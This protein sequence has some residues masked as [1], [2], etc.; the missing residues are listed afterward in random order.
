MQPTLF[1]CQL[2]S[3]FC[4]YDAV[5]RIIPVDAIGE[6]YAGFFFGFLDANLGKRNACS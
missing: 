6:R 2:T 1:C 5:G 4:T 3:S